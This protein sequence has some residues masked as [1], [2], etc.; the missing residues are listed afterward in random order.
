MNVLDVVWIG[1]IGAGFVGLLILTLIFWVQQGR[2]RKYLAAL[3][4]SFTI[5]ALI[6][7]VTALE[8][9]LIA[10]VWFKVPRT[11]GWLLVA[12]ASTRMVLFQAGYL[13]REK[14]N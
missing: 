13:N 6:S 7:L 14:K 9:T 12:I 4:I 8:S 1:S 10:T 3:L 5:L 11:I 2:V